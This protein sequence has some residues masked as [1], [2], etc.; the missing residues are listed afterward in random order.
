MARATAAH[1]EQRST[2]AEGQMMSPRGEGVVDTRLLG[3]P[4]SFRWY[5]TVQVHILWLRWGSGHQAQAEHHRERG[6]D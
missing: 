2:E 4:K 3:K 6:V 1:A 5:Q